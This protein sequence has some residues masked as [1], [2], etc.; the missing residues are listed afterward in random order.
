MLNIEKPPTS[1]R[2]EGS[3][4]TSGP[5]TVG[6]LARKGPPGGKSRYWYP[7]LRLWRT[8][9]RRRRLH[10]AQLAS[11]RMS[12]HSATAC[13]NKLL[14]EFCGSAIGD[15]LNMGRVYGRH[16]GLHMLAHGKNLAVDLPQFDETSAKPVLKLLLLK[17]N[18]LFDLSDVA[19]INPL[20]WIE[21]EPPLQRFP[22]LYYPLFHFWTKPWNLGDG[23]G[24]NVGR[25]LDPI[26]FQCL[27][28]ARSDALDL[29]M[30]DLE[31]VEK[32]VQL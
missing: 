27:L 20:G 21:R 6:G 30:L 9:S 4:S 22:P 24:R 19:R 18:V 5:T 25:G 15:R 10:K 13:E 12:C 7:Y 23:E 2:G 29:G 8:A 28:P 14:A 3:A 31:A 11:D 17:L 32:A 26:G 1:T 16:L